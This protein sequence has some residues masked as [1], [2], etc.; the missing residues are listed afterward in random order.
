MKQNNT[1]LFAKH[2]SCE[3][4]LH[5]LSKEKLAYE[6]R[7]AVI[8]NHNQREEK[9]LHDEI[10][11]LTIQ[12]NSMIDDNVLKKKTIL[13]YEEQISALKKRLKKMKT[14]KGRL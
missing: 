11:V 14:N 2:A 10:N 3:S 12:N 7:I 1:F 5:C 4:D 13:K 8:K 9:K 6:Q